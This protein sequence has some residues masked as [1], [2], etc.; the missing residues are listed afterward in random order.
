M[1]GKEAERNDTGRHNPGRGGGLDTVEWK[2]RLERR[3]QVGLLVERRANS[4]RATV[5]ISGG[6]NNL[7]IYG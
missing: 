2:R 3:K 5:A 1:E 4:D 7:R 6:R